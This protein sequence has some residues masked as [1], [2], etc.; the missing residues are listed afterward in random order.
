[1]SI[2]GPIPVSAV[3][4]LSGVQV[5][6]GGAVVLEV[7]ALEIQAGEILAVIGPNGAGK[8]TLLRVIGL[9]EVPTAGEV[10]FKGG[11]GGGSGVLAA[12][13]RMATVFQDPLLV[14]DTVF[15]NVALGLRF[16]RV[17]DA[18]IASRVHAWL[19]RFGIGALAARPARTLS[20]GQAQRPAPARGPGPSPS[21]PPS[22][23]PSTAA[24]PSWRSSPTAR[25]RSSGSGKAPRLSPP[26][27]PPPPTSSPE[28]PCDEAGAQISRRV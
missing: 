26:S 19:G 4:T 18:E 23:R 22:G 7:P 20:G 25:W 10:R 27:R 13:R 6:Y 14:D 17:A 1:M 3:V 16:R 21:G 12:R 9:L 11:T 8:S 5:A 15:G 24:F 2:P 28:E